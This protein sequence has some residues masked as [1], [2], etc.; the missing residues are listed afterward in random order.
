MLPVPPVP[1]VGEISAVDALVIVDEDMQFSIDATREEQR[2]AHRLADEAGLPVA[3]LR[4][5][6]RLFVMRDA[7][8]IAEIQDAIATQG[9]LARRQAEFTRDQAGVARRQAELV[10]EHARRDSMRMQRQA[11]EEARRMGEQAREQAARTAELSRQLATLGQSP[12]LAAS[13]ER[14]R[15][16]SQQL[17]QLEHEL[18]QLRDRGDATPTPDD[19]STE[20]LERELRAEMDRIEDRR[21][22]LAREMT[23]QSAQIGRRISDALDRAFEKGLA[24]PIERPRP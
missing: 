13:E 3:L 14:L 21:E 1:M 9:A 16:I 19:A 2:L 23:R 11:R 15:G 18:D 7:K 10:G 20:N 22:A 6:G 8:T 17:D 12:E 24:E 4:R 5:D